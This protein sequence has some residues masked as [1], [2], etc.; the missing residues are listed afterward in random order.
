[1]VTERLRYDGGWGLDAELAA[2][3]GPAVLW[4]DTDF[5][6]VGWEADRIHEL[7]GTG[8]LGY[9]PEHGLL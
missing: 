6:Q 8:S 9:L 3:G 2:R 1:M 7:S 4:R 5:S